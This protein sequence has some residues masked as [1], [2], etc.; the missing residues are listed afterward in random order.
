MWNATQSLEERGKAGFGKKR[1]PKIFSNRSLNET[2]G[3]KCI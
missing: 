1:D 2:G 3:T